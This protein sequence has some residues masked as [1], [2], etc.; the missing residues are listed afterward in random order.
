MSDF[1]VLTTAIVVVLVILLAPKLWRRKPRAAPGQFPID[2]ERDLVLACR[3]DRAMA[4]RLLQRELKLK[5][6]L[7]RTGAAL[8]AL[9][10]LRDDNR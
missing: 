7:S 9:S 6:E 10:R 4:E 2:V 3:G 8:M 5:P 1:S